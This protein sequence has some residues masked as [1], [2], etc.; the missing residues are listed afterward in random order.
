MSLFDFFKN[1]EAPFKI[2]KIIESEKIGSH[3]Q[4]IT[5]KFEGT[6]KKKFPVGSYIQPL[7]GGYV[8]RAYSVVSSAETTCTIIVS[9]SGQ[10]VGAR[11]FAQAPVGTEIKVYGPFDDFPYRAATGRPKVFIATGTGVAPFVEMVLLAINEGVESLLLMGSSTLVDIP[12]YNYFEEL[13]SK[14]KNFHFM[15]VLSRADSS[16]K[17]RR[18]Y[19]GQILPGIR[20]QLLACDIYVCGV[21][22]MISDVKNVLSKMDIPKEQ[23]FVQKFG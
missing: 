23:I 3:I 4:K 8:P 6:N 1:L 22:P 10:G 16:W 5:L 17:G 9:F 20:D 14:Y 19:V 2:M 21:P 13:S 7:I 11:F 12:F 18:G 15:P